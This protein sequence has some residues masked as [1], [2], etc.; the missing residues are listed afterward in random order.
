MLQQYVIEETG[1]KKIKKQTVLRSVISAAFV[2]V[3]LVC[4]DIFGPA[5]N[6]FDSTTLLFV[7]PVTSIMIGFSIYRGL[8]R[9]KALTDSF[10]VTVTQDMV[11]RDQ[12]NTPSVS[13]PLDEIK[14]IVRLRSGTLVIT[15]KSKWERICVPAQVD[16]YDQL[17]ASLNNIRPITA[18][19]SFDIPQKYAVLI[20]L[21]IIASLGYVYVGTNKIILGILGP[22]VLGAIVYSFYTFRK[23]KNIDSKSKR[24]SWWLLVVGAS[25]AFVLY[26]KLFA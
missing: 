19:K 24:T 10:V 7:L 22:I 11:K 14:E 15:G 20:S 18:K 13:I 4:F 2:M 16:R 12:F 25:V 26:T 8:K 21:A 23:N 6:T 9:K 5:G 17:E 3:A 1:F